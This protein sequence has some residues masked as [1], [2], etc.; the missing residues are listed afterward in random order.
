[1]S[2]FFD[3]ADG[4]NQYEPCP[5]CKSSFGMG[6]ATRN[7]RLA[8]Q[9]DCGHRGP[10]VDVPPPAQWSTWPVASHERDRQAFEGWNAHARD[11]LQPVRT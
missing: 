11:G 1:M 10:D 6:L 9:C 2:T 5:S 3:I 8:V 4:R 7:G